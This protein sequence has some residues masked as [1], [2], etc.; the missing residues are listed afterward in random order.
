MRIEGRYYRINARIIL[1]RDA[2]KSPRQAR[3]DLIARVTHAARLA[4]T[5]CKQ[6]NEQ[7]FRGIKP[8]HPARAPN[9][10]AFQ[11]DCRT[12]LSPCQITD[13]DSSLPVEDRIGDDQ[14]ADTAPQLQ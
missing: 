13:G 4:V 11:L 9:R 10:D 3:P 14:L 5:Y 6:V 7:T 8:A 1:R 2:T 12:R